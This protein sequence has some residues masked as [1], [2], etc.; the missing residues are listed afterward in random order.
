[1]I[2]FPL[3]FEPYFFIDDDGFCLAKETDLGMLDLPVLVRSKSTSDEY[4]LPVPV[5]Y[6][7]SNSDE[8]SPS[9]ILR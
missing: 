7:L 6:A 4:C 1:M 8:E 2:I 9:E 3:S 5:S